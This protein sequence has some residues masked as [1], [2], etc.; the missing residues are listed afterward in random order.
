M[1]KFI[2]LLLALAAAFTLTACQKAQAAAEA[3]P[4]QLLQ[5]QVSAAPENITDLEDAGIRQSFN[6]GVHYSGVSDV[7]I[8]LDGA[9]VSLE[10]AIRQGTVDA[11]TLAYFGAMDTKN[12]FCIRKQDSYNGLNNETFYYPNYSVRLVSDVL[13]AAGGKQYPVTCLAVFDHLGSANVC[14]DLYDPDTGISLSQEDWGLTFSAQAD[15]HELTVQYTQHGGTALGTLEVDHAVLR[16]ANGYIYGGTEE[17][18]F[19]LNLD[20]TQITMDQSG[21]FTCPLE[22]DIPAGEYTLYLTLRDVC[23]SQTAHSG[24]RNQQ[25]YCVQVNIA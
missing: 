24:H 14:A 18:G 4:Q 3:S 5:L 22:G 17:H 7:R 25:S 2:P 10:D 20:G 19:L 13:E 15:G 11:D 23:D 1:K 6:A 12:G 21:S 8:L 16:D 9:A